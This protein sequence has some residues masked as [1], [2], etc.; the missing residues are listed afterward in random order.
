MQTIS[1][2][3]RTID[4]LPARDRDEAVAELESIMELREGP[5]EVALGLLALDL[6][7]FSPDRAARS[8][9]T[10]LDHRITSKRA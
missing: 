6:V 2:L 8:S 9:S 4:T 1:D 7:T 10:L 5:R 3:I